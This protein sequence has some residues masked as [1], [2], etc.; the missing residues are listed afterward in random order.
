M[1][2]PPKK[3]QYSVDDLLSVK[4][5]LLN[6]PVKEGSNNRFLLQA[7]LVAEASWSKQ[8][9]YLASLGIFAFVP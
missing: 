4:L 5:S 9:V 1:M 6:C 3:G 7:G 2:V 8:A